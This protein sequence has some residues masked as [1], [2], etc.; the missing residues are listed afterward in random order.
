AT[1]RPTGGVRISRS[2]R[3]EKSKVEILEPAIRPLEWRRQ[4]NYGSPLGS[5][6]GLPLLGGAAAYGTAP[7]HRDLQRADAACHQ[8]DAVRYRACDVA[9]IRILQVF[10]RSAG[11]VGGWQDGPAGAVD[12]ADEPDRRESIAAG[13]DLRRSPVFRFRCGGLLAR[14]ILERGDRRARPGDAHLD[15]RS[16]RRHGQSRA[17]AQSGAL[18]AT[19]MATR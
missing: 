6:S 11:S 7:S 14:I 1:R 12:R 4:E 13:P 5:G 8:G 16:A 2:F 17:V 19:R 18:L 10:V 3:G 15:H 9:P